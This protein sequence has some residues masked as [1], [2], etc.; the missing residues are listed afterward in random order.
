VS[1]SYNTLDQI[2]TYKNGNTGIQIAR[3]QTTDSGKNDGWPAYNT[4]LNCTSYLNAD[5]GYEDAD[6]FAAKLTIGDGNVFDGCISAYNA[7]DGWDCFAKAETGAIGK[8]TIQN[9]VAYKNGYVLLNDAGELDINGKE[10]SAGNGNGFKMGGESITGYHELRNSIAFY[11]KAKGIDSNSCPDIQA[12]N[13]ITFNNESYNVAF[14]TNNAKNTDFKASGVVSF[15][16]EFLDVAEQLKPVG[17]QDTTQYLNENNFF[18]DTTTQTSKNTEGV[19]VDASWFKSLDF[20][21]VDRTFARNA[22]GSIN[23]NGFLELTDEAKAIVDAGIGATSSQTPSVGDE[24]GTDNSGSTD[25]GTDNSGNTDNGTDNSTDNST[26]TD[27]SIT[28][29]NKDINISVNYTDGVLNVSLSVK[30]FGQVKNI[31]T[32]IKLKFW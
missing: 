28:V 24:V 19:T 7:D 21:L 17:T 8:V 16:T 2:N 20:S 10:V 30:I 4:I 27:N 23:M 29:G 14:Y 22:D 32:S 3:Y 13:S 1:G 5:A 18:W 25:N 31:S 9:C 26:N 12:Y 11:N 6:G 15:R